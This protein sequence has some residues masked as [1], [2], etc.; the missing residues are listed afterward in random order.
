MTDLPDVSPIEHQ[1][2]IDWAHSV[3][4]RQ[5]ERLMGSLARDWN[6][7]RADPAHTDRL[8]RAACEGGMPDELVEQMFNQPRGEKLSEFD[9]PDVR[10]SNSVLVDTLTRTMTEAGMAT[11]GRRLM[12][13]SLASGQV[14]AL[15]AANS[16]DEKHYH[17]FVDADLMVF[18]HSVAKLV[19][20][21]L[22]RGNPASGEASLDPELVSRN[23][24]SAELQHRAA[25][26]FGAT[27][28]YG[29]P[30]ASEPW[31]PSAAAM[32]LV[33]LL[34]PA[35]TSFPLAHE[36]GH[37]HLG[38]LDAEQTQ[39]AEV[40]GFEDLVASIYAHED[41]FQ[42]DAVGSVV[43]FQTTLRLEVPN[44]YTALAPYIFLKAVEI[45][46]ACF[47]IFEG[48]KGV[49]SFTHP[50][51]TDRSR[52]I[53]RVIALHLAYHQSGAMLPAALN[54]V[55]RIMHWLLF[56][57]VTSLQQLKDQ[58]RTPRERVRLRAAE[59]GAGVRILGLVPPAALA[60]GA[61]AGPAIDETAAS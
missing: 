54:A 60:A 12:V 37:L 56:A 45:L 38:H 11:G 57:A 47:E 4:A 58:G 33:G 13:S 31:A 44:I 20:E 10:R 36:L 46:D 15:C 16:W 14:N 9:E 42:A 48:Q 5:A 28:L 43:T 40:E 19:A 35:L 30:R 51:A 59:E 1:G 7:K 55:D 61:G 6:G 32:P 23:A 18:C 50:S 53:R 27:V 21:C 24:R 29:T 26:L 8:I 41:E 17:I 22:V 25:D 34:S 3:Q 49:M 39:T 2:A 52:A